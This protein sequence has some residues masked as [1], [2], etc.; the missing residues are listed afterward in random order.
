MF[1]L[2]CFIYYI[3]ITTIEAVILLFLFQI[4]LYL[5]L[6]LF[7]LI[8]M[9]LQDEALNESTFHKALFRVVCSVL[10]CLITN[11]L[12]SGMFSSHIFIPLKENHCLRSQNTNCFF[13][14]SECPIV[15]DSVYRSHWNMHLL[16][17]LYDLLIKHV[18]IAQEDLIMKG[19]YYWYMV[20]TINYEILQLHT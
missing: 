9:W 17:P 4:P 19:L 1:L 7:S 10:P 15:P 12:F 5:P 20:S 3:A 14:N 11:L 13:R 8:M 16:S 2:K 6:S 18:Q